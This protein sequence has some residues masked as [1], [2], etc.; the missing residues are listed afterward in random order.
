LK[1]SNFTERTLHLPREG[2]IQGHLRY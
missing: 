2:A 1:K